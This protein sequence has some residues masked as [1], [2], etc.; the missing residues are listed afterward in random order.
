MKQTCSVRFGSVCIAAAAAWLW[1]SESALGQALAEVVSG[2][3]T[4]LF[5]TPSGSDS[6]NGQTIRTAYRTI[7]K[8]VNSV[9]RPGTV[10]VVAPGVYAETITFTSSTRKGNKALPM[11]IVGDVKGTATGWPAGE[12][13][14]DGGGSLAYGLLFNAGSHWGF[15]SLRFTGQTTANVMTDASGVSD[16][17][18]DSCIF[19][20]TPQWGVYFANHGNLELRSNTFTRSAASGHATYLYQTSG[21]EMVVT[22]N[23]LSMTGGDYLSSGYRRGELMS[24]GTRSSS[25]GYAYGIIAMAAVPGSMTMTIQNNVVSDA[26]LGLYVYNFG[27]KQKASV[28]CSNNTVVGCYYALYLAT[29]DKT[30]A[31]ITNNIAGDSYVSTYIQ[32][33]NAVL[34]GHLA[35]GMTYDPCGGRSWSGCS[36]VT[37]AK[38]GEVILNQPPSFA[39]PSRGDFSLTGTVGIDAGTPTGAP[40]TDVTGKRRPVDGD[41]DGVARVDVGAFESEPGERR[42]AVRIIQWREM[43]ADEE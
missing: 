14:I 24:G 12:V 31:T 28:V 30:T 36:Y 33:K 3:K 16:I 11:W 6:N 4:T 9:P 27:N 40:A 2:A 10:I 15:G 34:D 13:V 19:D 1:C 39:D 17:E 5:V 42:K 20:V 18:F 22:G 23:R 38:M 32:S 7:Q 41:G 37:V 21:S 26:Y 25:A 43:G 35:Y 29:D 8:A